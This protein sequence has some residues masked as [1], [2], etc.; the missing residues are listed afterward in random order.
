MRE[1]SLV[2][3][4]E[5]GE[6]DNVTLRRISLRGFRADL[7]RAEAVISN[8]GFELLAECLHMGIPLLVKPV[9]GQM[10]QHSNACALQQL[11]WGTALETLDEARIR[12]W[13]QGERR[14]PAIRYPD[15]AGTLVDW[16]LQGD[17]TDVAMLASLLWSRACVPGGTLSPA[18][19]EVPA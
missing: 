13:L 2:G 8:A 7:C 11:G 15:V 3:S 12:N 16:I 14:V 18:M 10:E 19:E 5:N 1:S 6:I 17:W 4:L 9:K